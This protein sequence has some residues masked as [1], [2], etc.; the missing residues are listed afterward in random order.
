MAARPFIVLFVA[1]ALVGICQAAEIKKR[2]VV[3]SWVW[4]DQNQQWIQIDAPTGTGG[5]MIGAMPSMSNK[6]IKSM[7]SDFTASAADKM[8]QWQDCFINFFEQAYAS[9]QAQAKSMQQM[10][11]MFKQGAQAATHVLK[12]FANGLAKA[13]NSAMSGNG[14]AKTDGGAPTGKMNITGD[15][16]DYSN[17]AADY[18]H[19]ADATTMSN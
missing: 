16:V 12:T 7:M 5:M 10:P 18:L 2:D 9:V 6:D 14:K 19:H 8:S 4:D 13:A 17:F 3:G 1:V 15:N 11:Q